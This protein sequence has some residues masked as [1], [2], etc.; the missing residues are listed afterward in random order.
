MD[1]LDVAFAG[2]VVTGVVGT[3]A[4]LFHWLTARS[5]RQHERQLA[6]DA[7]LYE[8]R[9]AVYVDL[10][11]HAHRACFA[12]KRAP[13]MGDQSGDPMLEAPSDEEWSRLLGRVLTF[14]SDGVRAAAGAFEDATVV[15]WALSIDAEEAPTG[16]DEPMLLQRELDLRY[17]AALEALEALGRSVRAD[18]AGRLTPT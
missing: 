7:R 14:G 10:L 5:Q 9:S 1:A 13:S 16:R 8:S 18:L 6:H 12:M 11:T 17:G 3:L 15:F 2:V 4:P